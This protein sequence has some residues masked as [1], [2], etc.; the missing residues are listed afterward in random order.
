MG[1]TEIILLL[2]YTLLWKI[3][4]SPTRNIPTNRKMLS[5]P[6]L[7]WHLVLRL[8]SETPSPL[9]PSRQLFDFHLYYR[10]QHWSLVKEDSSFVDRPVN[11][12]HY[13]VWSRDVFPNLYIRAITRFDRKNKHDNYQ[14]ASTE[15]FKL[16]KWFLILSMIIFNTVVVTPYY[17]MVKITRAEPRSCPICPG[18][19]FNNTLLWFHRIPFKQNRH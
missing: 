19:T 4:F 5:H 2:C 8:V 15:T 12:V 14:S 3:A 18:V 16:R 6:T 17:Y 11:Y 9:R 13:V 7:M 10:L 1:I